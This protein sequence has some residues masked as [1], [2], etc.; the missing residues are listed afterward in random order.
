[1]KKVAIQKIQSMLKVTCAV[2]SFGVV[3]TAMLLVYRLARSIQPDV[4]EIVLTFE[5]S[6]RS[7]ASAAPQTGSATEGGDYSFYRKDFEPGFEVADDKGI[8]MAETPVEIFKIAYEN[9]EQQVTVDG[10]DDKVIAPGTANTYTF[11]LKNTGN[12]PLDYTMSTEVLFSD[13]EL[14]LPVQVRMKDYE[15]GYLC[16]NAEKMEHASIL[17]AVSD[18]ATLAAHSNAVYS[19]EW[20][21][22]FERGGAEEDAYD[23]LLGDLAAERDISMTVI[24]R[25]HAE[26]EIPDAAPDTGDDT[27]ITLMI[28]IAIAALAIVVILILLPRLKKKGDSDAEETPQNN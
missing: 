20:E 25:T 23:T 15:G 26:A 16:G 18:S 8:W 12:V 19:L 10:G 28:I 11:T 6:P 13:P 17:N 5:E 22:P 27:N 14:T 9:G 2:L 4:P 7:F 21:W 24:I 3:L 1:M